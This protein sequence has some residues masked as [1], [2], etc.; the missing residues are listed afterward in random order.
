MNVLKLHFIQL[1]SYDQVCWYYYHYPLRLI[2]NCT[3]DF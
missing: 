2:A 1:Y 3:H